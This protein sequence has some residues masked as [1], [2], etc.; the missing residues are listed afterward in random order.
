MARSGILAGGNWIVD[1][2][3]LVDRWPDQDT[4]AIIESESRGSGGSPFNLLLGLSRLRAG[5][6]LEAV[7]RVGEDADGEYVF[8]A[9]RRAGV[10]TRFLRAIPE[11]ST[12]YTDVM[13]V[14]TTGRRTFFHHAGANA[15]LDVEDFEP[16]ASNARIFHLG[17]L[18]LLNALDA[19][20]PV[21]GT[22]A[23]RVLARFRE[24]GFK[25]SVDVV[26]DLSE[27]FPR[28]VIPAL[29]HVDYLILNEI[30]AGHA[31]GIPLLHDGKVD[32]AALPRAAQALLDHGVQEWVVIH[33]PDGAYARARSSADFFFPSFD[34]PPEWIK[35]AVGAGDA[36]CGGMLYGLHEGWAM[37]EC[38]RLAACAAAASLAHL[39]CTEGILPLAETR[40]LAQRFPLRK[41]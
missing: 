5:I 16:R 26:S 6:P 32:E 14:K 12:S 7:G 18:M 33:F 27:R 10:N 36:F 29:P 40:A 23:A 24:A 41:R 39:T 11:H 35:S 31:T 30:E 19:P 15:R 8:E 17:Y 21:F 9:C 28:V 38:L 22:R 3:K 4:L 37:T 13:T 34:C 20:D 1:R 25:T 2:I